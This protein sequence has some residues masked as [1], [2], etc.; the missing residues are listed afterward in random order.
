MK[1]CSHFKKPPQRGC[2]PRAHAATSA[3]S[4]SRSQRSAGRVERKR[5][6]RGRDE[7]REEGREG[8]QFC[9]GPALVYIPRLCLSVDDR[10]VN[11]CLLSVLNTSQVLFVVV[12]SFKVLLF[13][14]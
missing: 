6:G 3:R 10:K 5:E 4:P 13:V 8:S 7:A 14:F 11:V 1:I 9:G 12:N 2:I